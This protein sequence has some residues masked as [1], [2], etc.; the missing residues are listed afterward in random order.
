MGFV[1]ELAQPTWVAFEVDE[2]DQQTRS[3]WSV[4]VQGAPVR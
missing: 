4:V 2:L 1:S 3:G